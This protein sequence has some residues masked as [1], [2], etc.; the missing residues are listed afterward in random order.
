CATWTPAGRRRRRPIPTAPWPTSPASA[1][2]KAT[3]WASCPTPSGR[4][5]SGWGAPTAGC[6]WLPGWRQRPP[7]TATAGAGGPPREGGS[8]MDAALEGQRVWNE[9]AGPAGGGEPWRAVGLTEAEYRRACRLLGREPNPLELGM[10]G[11]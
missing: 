7:G 4:W 3:W 5:R 6:C 10:L 2:R 8:T 9:A 1:T 11:V